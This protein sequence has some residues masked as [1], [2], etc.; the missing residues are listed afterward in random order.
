MKTTFFSS[1]SLD[2]C[3]KYK[4]VI[5]T[6]FIISCQAPKTGTLSIRNIAD[7]HFKTVNK[8]WEMIYYHGF[9]RKVI[10]P[11]GCAFHFKADS[12]FDFKFCSPRIYSG[13]YQVVNDTIFL[14]NV[15]GILPPQFIFVND[16]KIVGIRDSVQLGSEP[17]YY[18]SVFIFKR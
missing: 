10:Y 8:Q 7:T 17:D 16:N 13:H 6:I 5:F 1:N 3:S 4:V 9:R 18:R 15:N 2:F 14:S 11:V 12:T